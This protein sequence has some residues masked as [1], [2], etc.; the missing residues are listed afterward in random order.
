VS[1]M[2]AQATGSGL[3]NRLARGVETEQ[4]LLDFFRRRQVMTTGD[5][6]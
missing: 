6:L 1:A 3:W 2:A 4:E 5:D